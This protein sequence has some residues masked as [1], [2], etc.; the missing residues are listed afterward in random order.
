MH[1]I[2]KTTLTVL[3]FSVCTSV[4][5]AK[6]SLSLYLQK[7][8]KTLTNTVLLLLLIGGSGPAWAV[9]TPTITASNGLTLIDLTGDAYNIDGAR[10][11][12]LTF[13]F[14]NHSFYLTDFSE[15]GAF[16][17]P[18]S[19]MHVLGVP[20]TPS[21][22]YDATINLI[23]GYGYNATFDIL[24][25]SDDSVLV[26]G[27]DPEP[28]RT[29]FQPLV[30][31]DYDAGNNK[32]KVSYD[33]DDAG[34][35]SSFSINSSGEFSS[36]V[37]FSQSVEY[38]LINTD[39]TPPTITG[40]TVASDNSIIAVTI[41]EAV[42]NTTDGGNLE[43]S[44]FTLSLSG[45]AATLSSAAPSSISISGNVYI[46]GLSLSGTPNGSETVTVV[47]SS[48]T[49]IYDSAD[50]A[51][52][53]SQSNNTVTLV[54]SLSPTIT[55]TTVAS[56]NSII[57]VTISEAVYNTTDGGNL[58]AS[59]FTLSLS[60]GAATLS[61]AAPSSISIS[62]NV[63]ILGLSLSGTPNGSETVTVVPSSSTAIYDSA[64]NAAS[65]SQSNNTVTLVDS[66]SPTMTI[67]SVTVSDGAT[68]NDATL[69]LT[70]TSSEA[71]S[72]FAVGDIT[73]SGG[74]LSS[75]ATT[76][77]T[78]YTA[79][80]TPS[81][82][83]AATIDVAGSAFTDSVGNN[84]TAA[85][86]F[87]WTY[88]STSPT[89]TIT[90]VTVSDGATSNDATL[91]LTFTSSEAT[92]D[93]AVGDITISGGALSSFATTSSTVYTAIFTPSGDGAA[94]IDV[95]GS[96]FTDSVGNN[97][98]AA[99]QFNWT[100]D[101][102]SP[103][104]TITSAEMTDGGASDNATL[105][106]TFTSS[107]ATTN[108]SLSD[109]AVTNATLTS[110]SATSSTIYTATLTPTGEGAVTVDVTA[111][112][113]T[114]AASNN[115][116]VAIQFNW[117]HLLDPTTKVDVTGSIKA[118]VNIAS[119]RTQST[120]SA[121]SN[122]LGWL[123]SHKGQSKTSYQGIRLDFNDDI[124]NALMAAPSASF[125]QTN[126][127]NEAVN[128]VN[129]ANDSLSTL[130]SNLVNDV[131]KAALNEAAIVRQ[132]ATGTLNP[133]F[134]PVYNGWSL[135]TDGTV[136]IGDVD[137]T[138]SSAKQ[139]SKDY[140]ISIGLDKPLNDNRLVGYVLRTGQ[141][142]VDVGTSTSKVK[143]ESYSLAGYTAYEGYQNLL[144]EA[145]AGVG[146]VKYN[147]TRADGVHILKG[148]RAANQAFASFS[149]SKPATV[150]GKL[151][152]SPFVKATYNHTSFGAYSEIGGITALTYKEHAIHESQLAL[153][154]DVRYQLF[155][156]NIDVYPYA[157]V[158]Y[159]LDVSDQANEP[160][161]MYYNSAPSKIYS[162]ALD[163]RN[164]AS[165]QFAIGADL[166]T[167]GGINASLDY[168]RNTVINSGHSQSVSLRIGQAF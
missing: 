68:S 51:A 115:N 83:G 48:S 100:Y 29:P 4:Y 136:T 27:F 163:T 67:T 57:A 156:G 129:R 46:L 151:S 21:A 56:D 78:V 19:S 107:E 112:A 144:M 39:S 66:L 92:S 93:F 2:F 159:N 166:I 124:I 7:F 28:E 13:T 33:S 9:E 53:T 94:T 88:D 37:T 149:A 5:V 72:D 99:T 12:T 135:W 101:S 157:R 41:S 76:S 145:V 114:D 73:I 42:Y 22:G 36:A 34:S 49:A 85:T 59:D 38:T 105:A 162:L 132:N 134:K 79:I 74:A 128:Q 47:P 148:G 17:S 126:W 26:N 32:I 121:I 14:Q 50:N 61:S 150:F 96:A 65:T 116:T 75:F 10:A 16:G 104:M 20:S 133:A 152:L 91:A 113:F 141:G 122:R 52:S 45:G 54:D 82:D 103:T 64:D 147:L 8:L 153:G 154:T 167:M 97:N 160:A 102:T 118:S 60:G 90:S 43:A 146:V 142:S 143:S 155:V 3:L 62:G 6:N 125:T 139:S 77:S 1:N 84:N 161:Q 11:G 35:S 71:T 111:G 30:R 86:Q 23:P 58:E 87:N 109:I 158:A 15:I 69:A 119:Q 120:F 81:G 165:V 140:S 108:F 106:L 164:T 127:T 130:E 98:T 70:F 63:Y 24:E 25:G 31:I 131:T 55:G 44:D 123:K 95:A 80:F 168:L 117:T 138:A 89:M 110:F 18:S 40:T 137:A